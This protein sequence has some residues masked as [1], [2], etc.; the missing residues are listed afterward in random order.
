MIKQK[1]EF[2][3]WLAI[4]LSMQYCSETFCMTHD[5]APMHQSEE[6]AWEEGSDPCC[7]CVRIGHSGDWDISHPRDT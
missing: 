1:M 7:V 6:D 4:G 5:G 3:E 2:G